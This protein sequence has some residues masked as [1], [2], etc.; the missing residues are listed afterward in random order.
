MNFGADYYFHAG[1]ERMRQARMIYR[2]GE[3]YALAMYVA[4]LSVECIL[5]AFR[6]RANP[7]FEGR[8]DF[9]LLFKESG[10]LRL[11]E[12]QL[13]TKRIPEEQVLNQIELFHALMNTVVLFWTN[14]L[15]FAPESM[16]RARLVKMRRYERKKGDILR[17]RPLIYKMRLNGSLIEEH[18][19]GTGR[20]NNSGARK[21]YERRAGRSGGRRWRDRL[22]GLE[23]FSGRQF[24]RPPV[25]DPSGSPNFGRSINQG[26]G[27]ADWGN[28][29]AD[30]R[31][32]SRL[33]GI[34]PSC[35]LLALPSRP[36][37][38]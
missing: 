32:V 18:S 1:L 3:S 26:R 27:S 38:D 22:C 2:D 12:E 24:R 17:Q 36:N 25:D 37:W 35:G 8:H 9:L 33:V 19:C 31:R 14:D 29:R 28:R 5:R 4:G 16:V 15:R 21:E 34:A 6:W 20:K 7:A 30:T 11:N 13:R 23:G 10:L